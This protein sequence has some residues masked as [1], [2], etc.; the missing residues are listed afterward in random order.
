MKTLTQTVNPVAIPS[1]INPG[2]IVLGLLIVRVLIAAF[3]GRKIPLLS[4]VR[5]DLIVLIVL[6]MAMCT[7][8][9][10]GRVAALNA[11][12]HPLAIVGYVLG[13]AILL[14]TGAVFLNVKLPF[15]ANEQQALLLVAGLIGA[16]VINSVIHSLLTPG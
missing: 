2:M 8:G 11:W 13:A 9:G 15:I 7:S 5:F 16:K 6:G 3:S 12:G 10:I 14:V 1:P 4:I